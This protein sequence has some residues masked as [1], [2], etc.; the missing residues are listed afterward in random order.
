MFPE[1]LASF[2]IRPSFKYM[3]ISVGGGHG[4]DVTTHWLPLELDLGSWRLLTSSSL[5]SVCFTYYSCTNCLSSTQPWESRVLRPF[6]LYTWLNP[7]KTNIYT[8]KTLMAGCRDLLILQ[9]PRASLICEFPGLLKLPPT[10]LEC[11][12]SFF[13]FSLPSFV[14]GGHLQISPGELPTL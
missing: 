3:K 2:F 13:D 11:S 5:W 14:Y 6:E 7:A 10:N 9:M 4:E 8:F 1:Q 12:A